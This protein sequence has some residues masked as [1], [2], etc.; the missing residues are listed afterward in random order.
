MKTIQ[1]ILYKQN[2][3]LVRKT[4]YASINSNAK[5]SNY[6]LA[7]SDHRTVKPVLSATTCIKYNSITCCEAVLPEL[8]NT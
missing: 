5:A 3:P 1:S 8:L 6:I 2:Y 4:V 7:S